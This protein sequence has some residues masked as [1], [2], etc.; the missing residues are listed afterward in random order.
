[1]VGCHTNKFEKALDCFYYTCIFADFSDAPGIKFEDPGHALE[2]LEWPEG[3]LGPFASPL[4]HDLPLFD[5]T[6][7]TNISAQMGGTAFLHCRVR[8]ANDLR[9]RRRYTTFTLS[10][11]EKKYSW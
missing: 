11:N 9:V 3:I 8:N 5:N 7:V 10:R 6:L 2:G 1:M 4:P